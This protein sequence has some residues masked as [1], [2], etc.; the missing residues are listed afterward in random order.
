MGYHWFA[1]LL[2]KVTLIKIIQVILSVPYK[3][4]IDIPNESILSK[5]KVKY[6]ISNFQFCK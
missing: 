5:D 2:I 3:K 4:M 6:I 1:F